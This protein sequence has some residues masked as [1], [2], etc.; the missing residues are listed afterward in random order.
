MLALTIWMNVP[1]FHQD[2]LFKALLASGET[3]LRVVFATEAPPQRRQLGWLD[4]ARDYP[5]RMLSARFA[6]W[7]AVRIAWS[8]RGRLHIVSGI[9]AEP[10]FAAV[11]CVLGLARSRFVVYAEAPDPRQTPVG[12]HGA[13]RRWFGGWVARRAL[14]MLAVSHFGE[15]F[16][17]QLGFDAGRI[18]QFGYFRANNNVPQMGPTLSTRSKRTEVIFVGQLID[19]KGVDLLLEAVQPLLGDSPDLLLSVI[20]SGNEAQALRDKARALRVS[21]RVKFEG[22]VSSDAIQSRIASAD[23]LVLPSRWDG[24]GMVVNEA[25]SAGV[26]VIVSDRCGAADLIQHGVNGFVFRSEDIDGLRQCMRTFLDD[27]DDRSAMRSAAATSGRAV[28][29]EAAAPYLV[30]CLKHMTGESHTRPAPPWL[31]APASQSASH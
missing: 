6:F 28:A 1:S 30:G 16:Y 24:W 2:G 3:D 9:W 4:A 15:E 25:L 17:A 29:A 27:V 12:F 22:T 7:D 5:N 18:Y 20:G 14:G 11:L 26:P 13:F 8:E 31:P 10:S 23:V 21:D 19:R